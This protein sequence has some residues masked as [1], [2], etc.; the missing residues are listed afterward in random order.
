MPG[1]PQIR[2]RRLRATPAVRSLLSETRVHPHDLVAP[3]FVVEGRGVRRAI[4]SLPGQFH[5]SVERLEAEA[6]AL[7]ELGVPAVLLFGLPAPREKTPDARRAAAPDG[8]VQRAVARLKARVPGLLVVTDVCLCEYTS[9]GHCGLL[10]GD[11]RARPGSGREAR[12]LNDPSLEALARVAVS[13]ADAGADWVAPSDMMDGRVAA[14]RAALDEAGHSGVGILSYAAKAAS[15]FYGPFREAAASAPAFGDRRSHQMDPANG[16]EALREIALDLGE[17]ADMVMVKP[18]LPCLDL[19]ARARD[20]FDAPL[21]AYSVSGEYSMA[22]AAAQR[23]WGD[24]EAL[25][26]ETLTAVK[27]A[28]ADVLVTYWARSFAESFRRRRGLD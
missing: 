26:D 6:A 2:P 20:R 18:A 27:R 13:H 28:G 15:A 8:V 22:H 3:L 19:I 7:F 24:L 16:R 10:E 4:P 21:A 9:H 17:G 14:L 12:I 11:G 1:F 5:Y 23:G 25:R